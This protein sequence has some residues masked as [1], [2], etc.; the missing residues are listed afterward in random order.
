MAA[1]DRAHRL[2]RARD[3]AFRQV[4][5]VRVADR[6]VLDR[7]QAE[8]LRG[9]V[10]R[11]LQAAVVEHQR[12]G[13]AVFEEQ[14]AVVGAFEPAADQLPHLAAVEAGAVDQRS[15]DAHGRL[16]QGMPVR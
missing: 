15:G 8:A 12:F 9:V 1:L 11:L 16:R 6:F 4:G 2:G 14:F 5:G 3:R 7:A 10:G 13:L